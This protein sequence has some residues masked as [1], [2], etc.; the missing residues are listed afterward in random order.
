MSYNVFVQL[1]IVLGYL[2]IVF[3]EPDS[4]DID[5]IFLEKLR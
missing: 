2:G 1:Y 4:T 3:L 5:K